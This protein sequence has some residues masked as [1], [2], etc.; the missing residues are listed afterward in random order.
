MIVYQ[1]CRPRQDG[2]AIMR[3]GSEVRAAAIDVGQVSWFDPKSGYSPLLS[4]SLLILTV[5]RLDL[6][7]HA[8]QGP[9]D[10]RHRRQNTASR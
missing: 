1:A 6:L 5:V 3:W 4:E 9:L 2:G 10:S 8:R 7:T